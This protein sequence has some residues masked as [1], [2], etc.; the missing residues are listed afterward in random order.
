M[1]FGYMLMIEEPTQDSKKEEYHILHKGS[2]NPDANVMAPGI[3]LDGKTR[4]A[5][6]KN[7]Y[8]R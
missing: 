7:E 6:F 8:I 1:Y 2:E 5:D 4:Y 3:F